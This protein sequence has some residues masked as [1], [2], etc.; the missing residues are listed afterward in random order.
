MKKKIKIPRGFKVLNVEIKKNALSPFIKIYLEKHPTKE[1]LLEKAK[2]DYPEGTVF[3]VTHCNA[4]CTVKSHD[5]HQN[6]FVKYG[7]KLAINFLIQEQLDS[8]GACVWDNG[9]WAKIIKKPI[10]KVQDKWLYEGDECFRVSTEKNWELKD[11]KIDEDYEAI[12][13]KNLQPY[14]KSCYFLTKQSALDHVMVEA[15]IKFNGEPSCKFPKFEGRICGEDLKI[16]TVEYIHE[17]ITYLTDK[18]YN[19][20]CETE[21]WIAKPIKEAPLMLGD[22]EVE[23][24]DYM[25]PGGRSGVKCFGV[26]CDGGSVTKEEWLKYYNMFKIG[27]AKYS[28][29]E[30]SI[31]SQWML[32]YSPNEILI[33]CIEGVTIKQIEA[34]TSRLNEL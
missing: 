18:N 7:G 16:R 24:Y 10:I 27:L 4:I 26:R 3:K 8:S 1:Q 14:S 33:G 32:H 9:K 23:I 19:A 11:Y 28:V 12:D 17:S 5:A 21:G 2:R 29:F 30:F 25:T 22:C 20:W 31:D 6:T 15:K 13:F 34:I